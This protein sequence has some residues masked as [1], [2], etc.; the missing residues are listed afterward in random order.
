MSQ[1]KSGYYIV[2]MWRCNTRQL[3]QRVQLRSNVSYVAAEDFTRC[4]QKDAK[5]ND[6][7]KGAVPDA[8]RRMTKG[9]QPPWISKNG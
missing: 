4:R 7:L 5:L 6:C 8:L 9:N 3:P 2:I 1:R